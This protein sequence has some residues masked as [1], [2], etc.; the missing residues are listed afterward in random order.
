MPALAVASW[1]EFEQQFGPLTI[2]ERLDAMMAQ[3]A[4][5]IHA[6]AG[7]KEPPGRFTVRWRS[8]EP[9]SIIS[10]LEMQAART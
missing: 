4:Y 3:L 2:H 7:G 5:T 10:W 8:S 1:A 9:V 6:S